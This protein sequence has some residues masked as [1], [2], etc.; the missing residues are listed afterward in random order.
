MKRKKTIILT[1]L[2]MM[3]LMPSMLCAQELTP[4]NGD[5]AIPDTATGTTESVFN[6]ETGH[7][8]RRKTHDPI[9]SPYFFRKGGCG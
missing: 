3:A 9:F 4:D 7:A 5:E 1:Y 6:G 2:A 8:F